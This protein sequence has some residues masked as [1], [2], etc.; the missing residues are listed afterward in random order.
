MTVARRVLVPAIERTPQPP[1]PGARVRALAG[2]TMGTTWSVQFNAPAS[3]DV[4]DV[5]AMVQSALDRV[6][7]QMSTWQPDSVLS[8]F[9]EARAGTWHELPVEF[10]TVLQCALDLARDTGG[11]YDPTVGALVNAW[12]FGPAGD[13]TSCATSIPVRGPAC[14]TSAGD[15]INSARHLCGH[16]RLT[17]DAAQ[18]RVQ[19]PGGI[20]VDL[21]AIAKGFGVDEVARVLE[22]G[23]VDSYLVEVGG[24]LRGFGVKADGL[25]WWVELERPPMHEG[26]PIVIA[27]HGLAVATSGDYRRFVHDGEKTYSHT[28]DPRTGRPIENGVASVTVLHASCMHAD[29]LSTALTV[30]GAEAGLAYAEARGIA[31]HFIER[32]PQGFAEHMSSAMRAMLD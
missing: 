2:A 29:A 17:F 28:I 5:Q 12:G 18:A 13:A 30:L 3:I 21:S 14:E 7:Q 24:E 23:G 19:Q 15:V 6:V 27:L 10:A 9:N 20:Y 32:T 16:T 4:L 31:A 1:P 25:P 26:A 22:A 11:A 8:H